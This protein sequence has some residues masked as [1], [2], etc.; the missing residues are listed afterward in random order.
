MFGNMSTEC[1]MLSTS[2]H[3]NGSFELELCLPAGQMIVILLFE[4][5]QA[6]S[7]REIHICGTVS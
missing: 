6:I 7:I 3:S 5:I 2:P 4:V 1:R